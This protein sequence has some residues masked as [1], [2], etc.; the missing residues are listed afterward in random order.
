ML[1]MVILL[2]YNTDTSFR[3][4]KKKNDD[5]VRPVSNKED[6]E[7]QNKESVR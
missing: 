2:E 3:H 5:I 1:L 4:S 7:L 6:T